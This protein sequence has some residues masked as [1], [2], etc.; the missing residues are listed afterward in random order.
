MGSGTQ[1]TIRFGAF[2]LE[3]GQGRLLCRDQE[4][5]LRPK[6]VA[7]LQQLDVP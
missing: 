7:L 1:E 6:A 5:R 3:I 4:I 2:R